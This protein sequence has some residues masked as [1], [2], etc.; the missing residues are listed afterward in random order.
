V[1]RDTGIEPATTGST[2]AASTVLKVCD[3]SAL[4]V[5]WTLADPARPQPPRAIPA[6]A[7][8]FRSLAGSLR[9]V[10]E[11]QRRTPWPHL[12]NNLAIVTGN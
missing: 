6:V 10:V 4:I 3:L 1:V 9:T 8:A 11:H 5:T 7:G 2:Q 12:G